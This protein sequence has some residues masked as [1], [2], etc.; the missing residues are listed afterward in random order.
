MID[1][2]G[3]VRH[4]IPKV[5]PAT[6]DDEVLAAIAAAVA[7]AGC[8]MVTMSRLTRP[9]GPNSVTAMRRGVRQRPPRSPP[10]KGARCRRSRCGTH[11]TI[12]SAGSP[13]IR[14]AEL[15]RARSG[16]WLYAEEEDEDDDLY[17]EDD[18]GFDDIDEDDD[19]DATTTRIE[20]DDLDD[21]DDGRR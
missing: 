19:D 14:A 1:A 11:S 12:S 13:R 2:E 8:E 21:A 18:L 6:H 17:G 7:P 15:G 3:V 16:V 5:S 9:R 10:R 4:V 20:E